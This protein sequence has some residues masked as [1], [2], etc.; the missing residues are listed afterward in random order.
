MFGK[1]IGEMRLWIGTSTFTI[2]NSSQEKVK[3]RPNSSAKTYTK[4]Y[5]MKQ[6][7]SIFKSELDLSQSIHTVI[8]VYK[9]ISLV[10]T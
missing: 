8:I 7:Y 10:L 9:Y 4:S 2:L 6:T 5:L 1:T 3:Q